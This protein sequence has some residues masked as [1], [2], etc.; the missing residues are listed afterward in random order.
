MVDL[1]PEEPIYSTPGP[2]EE[3]VLASGE[4]VEILSDGTT[5]K[6]EADA[7]LSFLPTPRLAFKL[8]IPADRG[9]L[10]ARISG[11]NNTIHFPSRALKTKVLVSKLHTAELFHITLLPTSEPVAFG[12]TNA[13]NIQKVI[14]HLPNFHN[15]L[16]T[17]KCIV[18]EEAKN[19]SRR[20]G[21]VAMEGEDWLIT[22]TAMPCTN[23]NEEKLKKIGGYVITHVGKIERK[24]KEVFSVNQVEDM[25]LALN[26]FLSFARGFKTFPLLPVGFDAQGKQVWG[27]WGAGSI[28]QWQ[29]VPSWFDLLH[30]ELIAEL[31]PGFLRRWHD[32]VWKEPLGDAIYWY[33]MGN[34]RAGGI[35][36]ATILI[37]AALE[38]LAWVYTVEDRVL[39]SKGGFKKLW[40]S[41]K[42]R[43]LLR[44]LDIPCEI[45]D[46][47]TELNAAAKSHNWKDGPH[48]LTEL[49]NVIIHPDRKNK[50]QSFMVG[51][52]GWN[53]GLWYVELTLLKLFGHKGT[54]RN[55]LTQKWVGEVSNVPW[56][57]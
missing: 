41:D 30:G 3:I 11:S 46:H 24:N 19:S 12:D 18:E 34:T 10:V 1:L 42:L 53:L 44:S 21:A 57:T 14:F 20:L 38:L 9:D 55:R 13:Q 45:P 47:L 36:G 54:Y 56:A 4:D 8:T 39:I 40:A 6:S 16:S 22:L 29:S 28:H 31:F 32:R 35:D 5:N 33:L 43:L 2:N 26:C 48:A 15:F 49:R 37:Q 23:D 17:T 7:S 51:Y 50:K 27:Q 25:L 52:E